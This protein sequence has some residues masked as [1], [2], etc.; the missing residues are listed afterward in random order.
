MSSLWR[1]TSARKSCRL[2]AAPLTGPASY[3]AVAAAAGAAS[4]S[5]AGLPTSSPI[6]SSSRGELLDLVFAE[7][8]LEGERLE[9]CRLD[10]AALLGAL[11]QQAGLIAFQQFVQLVLRQVTLV[12]LSYLLLTFSVPQTFSP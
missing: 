1:P 10:V 6:V 8:V 5:S 7:V 2:S 3:V 9:L 4:A 11:D 12:V